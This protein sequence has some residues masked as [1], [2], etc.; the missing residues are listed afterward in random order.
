MVEGS[1]YLQVLIGGVKTNHSRWWRCRRQ[2]FIVAFMT[3]VPLLNAVLFAVIGLVVFLVACALAARL[4]PFEVWKEITAERNTAA[5]IVSGAVALG[6]AWI[7]AA[8]MH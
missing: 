7:V 4:A 8:A 3:G 2:R 5:A 1:R 6:L